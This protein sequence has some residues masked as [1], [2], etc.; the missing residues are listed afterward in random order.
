M[1]DTK[2]RLHCCGAHHHDSH[3]PAGL[4][5]DLNM[6]ENAKESLECYGTGDNEESAILFLPSIE[7]RW[8]DLHTRLFADR[9]ARGANVTVLIPNLTVESTDT[10]VE[11]GQKRTRDDAFHNNL[12]K[13]TCMQQTPENLAQIATHLRHTTGVQFLGT[14]GAHSEFST[15]EAAGYAEI[16]PQIDC[17]VILSLQNAHQ[18]QHPEAAVPTS[19]ILLSSKPSE[20]LISEDPVLTRQTTVVPHSGIELMKDE[21]SKGYT[22]V[23]KETLYF[24]KKHLHDWS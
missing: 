1:V 5:L 9:L 22:E 18:L 16:L 4:L 14:F 8:D 3:T 6:T 24:F 13:T 15:L 20:Q 17:A 10:L 11:N 7:Y 2:A 19:T 21:D 12:S 23:M